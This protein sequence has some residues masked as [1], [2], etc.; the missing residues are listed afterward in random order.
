MVVEG[1][2]LEPLPLLVA[3]AGVVV[4]ALVGLRQAQ[5]RRNVEEE[6]PHHLHQVV[7]PAR[8]VWADK[9]AHEHHRIRLV[10]E[11]DG[12]LERDE[13]AH[14]APHEEHL[15]ARVQLPCPRHRLAEVVRHAPYVSEVAVGAA[16]PPVPLVVRRHDR[17]PVVPQEED[18]AH[19][20]A[21]VAV[22]AVREDHHRPRGFA[23]QRREL[24]AEQVDMRAI[25]A[26]AHDHLALVPLLRPRLLLNHGRGVPG[27]LRR[28][29]G[30]LL[31]CGWPQ[32]RPREEH[33]SE[34]YVGRNPDEP[35]T[36]LGCKLEEAAAEHDVEGLDYDTLGA[37]PRPRGART[38]VDE[39]VTRGL[40][41]SR[42]EV[43]P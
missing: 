26:V 18:V 12:G 20:V 42:C 37:L 11:F 34:Q 4:L 10:L 13:A 43:Q 22:E 38:Q 27:P 28:P 36:L 3:A 32:H 15:L 30:R 39:G 24:L 21:R 19:H 31:R 1:V 7:R 6:S 16:G 33:H 5:A 2:G 29:L 40:H 14:G 35:I 41:R 17:V 8:P 9:R 25:R 23:P